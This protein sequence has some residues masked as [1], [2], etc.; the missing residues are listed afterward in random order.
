MLPDGQRIDG[1]KAIANFLGRERST[2]IRWAKERGLP[3]QR[4]PGGQTGTIYAVR[5]EL[6]AWLASD[7]RAV[8]EPASPA[9]PVNSSGD[10]TPTT[11]SKA[12]SPAKRNLV[13][14]FAAAGLVALLIVLS[15]RKPSSSNPP[16]SIA[17]VASSAN[18]RDASEFA[19]ALNA[20]LARFAHA[21]PDLAVFESEAG[22]APA[23]QYTVR[24]DIERAGGKV[25]AN[26]RLIAAPNGQL[27]WSRQF[28]QGGPALSALREEVAANLV[29]VLRCS[30]GGLGSERAKVKPADLEQLVCV[31][32]SRLLVERACYDYVTAGVVDEAG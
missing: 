11:P 2:A 30:F 12:I 26:A 16:V 23:T 13:I 10:V 21:S 28:E 24:T 5:S 1:W 27:V 19:S 14:A 6:E 7:R 3:V 29:D 4:V 22:T 25:I 20:D 15:G 9:D 18:N 8:T 31:A 17:A 32:G